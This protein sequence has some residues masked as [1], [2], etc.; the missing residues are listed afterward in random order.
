MLLQITAPHFVAGLVI[1]EGSVKRV[2]P[3]IK[4]MRGYTI[5]KVR[6]YCERKG[7]TLTLV[8]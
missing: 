6:K 4:Y 3:I 1:E 7:W 5:E 8:S 2:A